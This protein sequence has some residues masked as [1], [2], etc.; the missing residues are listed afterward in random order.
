MVRTV[1]WDWNGTL[2]NDVEINFSIINTLLTRRGLPR[3]SLGTYRRYFRM[4]IREFY[5]DIGFRFEREPFEAIAKEYF[6]LYR[7]AFPRA[8][9]SAGVPETLAYL[10]DKGVDQHI[11]SASHR[12]D[13]LE[14][15]RLRGIEPFFTRIVGNDDYAVVSKT[16]KALELRKELPDNGA[17]LFIG[18]M[19]HD[20]ETARAIGASCLLYT[21]GHQHVP[22]SPEY[23]RID[24]FEEVK[25]YV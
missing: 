16:A 10:K 2:I 21:K 19:D 1:I 9:L 15:V 22:E 12:K 11:V 17:I 3:I 4:P 14:Q 23:I 5:T 25:N 13:L 8:G 24:S 6:F 18:D 7:D 20:W